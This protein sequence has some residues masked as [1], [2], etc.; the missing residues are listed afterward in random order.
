M[1]VLFVVI[2]LANVAL[3][4]WEYRRGAFA[5]VHKE[6]QMSGQEPIK[7]LSEQSSGNKSSQ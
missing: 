5:P 2:L 4:M 1:K 6:A 3:F 7:L